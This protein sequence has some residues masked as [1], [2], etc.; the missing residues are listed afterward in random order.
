LS[1]GLPLFGATRDANELPRSH[2][3]HA[4][5][6]WALAAGALVRSPGEAV[7]FRRQ[8]AAQHS[9]TGLIGSE[10]L[11]LGGFAT[12]RGFDESVLAG[13]SGH[14]I[15]TELRLPGLW[16]VHATRDGALRAFRP[17]GAPHGGRRRSA[18]ARVGAGLRGNGDG[19][20]GK[21]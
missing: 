8:F 3:H 7:E 11:Y 14:V 6:K 2:I 18:L 10:Q 13:D 4:F 16:A 1:V 21:V 19:L 17:W 5:T 9:N 20:S 12:V 15:R